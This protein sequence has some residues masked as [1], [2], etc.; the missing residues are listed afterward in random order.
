MSPV[1]FD[2]NLI[3]F[4]AV[5]EILLLDASVVMTLFAFWRV[6]TLAGML[7]LPYIAWLCLATALTIAIWKANPKWRLGANAK[8][9]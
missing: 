8:Q 2:N 1:N 4:Q 5:F 3:L 9:K 6:D 7:L